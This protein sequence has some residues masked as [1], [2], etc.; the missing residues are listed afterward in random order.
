MRKAVIFLF[1]ISLFVVSCQENEPKKPAYLIDEEKMVSMMVDM[2]IVETAANLKIYN[3]DSSGLQYD[4]AFGSI[5][6]T[7]NVSKADFDSSLYYYSTQTDRMDVIYDKVLENL[8]EQ[9][10]EVNSAQ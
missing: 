4:E 3:P 10:S 7:N 6:A 8:S 2:H 5:F 9:E 1:S